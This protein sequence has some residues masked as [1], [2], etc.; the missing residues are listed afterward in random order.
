ML[1]FAPFLQR[2]AIFIR[3]SLF[4]VSNSLETSD[5]EVEPRKSAWGNLGSGETTFD[6]GK[7][8]Q[9]LPTETRT[10]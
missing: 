8:K 2:S 6:R 3:E 9:N 10:A 1:L 7:R 5:L 4:G